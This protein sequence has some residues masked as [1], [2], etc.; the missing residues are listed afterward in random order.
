M[1]ARKSDVDP[2]VDELEPDALD[3]VEEVD[4]L[5]DLGDID[6]I[7]DIEDIDDIDDPD[8][9]LDEPALDE[10]ELDDDFAD[11]DDD[12]ATVTDGGTS[13]DIDVEP[14]EPEDAD[15]GPDV[16]ASLLVAF[17]GEDE[18]VVALVEDED[19]DEDVGVREGEF[20]CRSCFMAMRMSALADPERMICRD[21]A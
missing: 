6:D 19:D 12:A 16:D 17:D 20:V 18:D 7:D 11:D 15:A 3:E 9:E 1:A 14:L 10:A 13:E 8:L 21:C 5:D 2:A 4:D